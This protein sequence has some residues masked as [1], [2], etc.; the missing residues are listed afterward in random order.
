MRGEGTILVIEDE[1]DVME[2]TRETLKRLGY[3]VIEA[4]TGK[5]AI[6]KALSFEGTIDMALLDI[7]LPDMSGNQLYPL[8]MNARPDLKVVV[9]SGYALDGPARE[10]LDAGAEGFVQKPFSISGL[11]QKLKEVLLK[12]SC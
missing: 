2:I 6:Q 7:K 10:I 3:V 12:S 5:E 11:S 1:P 4:V 9:F 8:I